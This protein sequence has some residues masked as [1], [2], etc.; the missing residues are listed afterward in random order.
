MHI[1]G[2]KIAIPSNAYDAKGL[3]KTALRDR[4]PVL[5]I[6]NVKLYAAKAEVPEQQYCIPFGEARVL[7]QG[8]WSALTETSFTNATPATAQ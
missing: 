3:M 1:P 6:E 5:F 7:K 4:N 2:L 8:T